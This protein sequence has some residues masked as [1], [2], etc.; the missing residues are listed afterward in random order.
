MYMLFIINTRFV[1]KIYAY[2]IAKLSNNLCIDIRYIV[3]FKSIKFLQKLTNWP[4]WSFG[5]I[6]HSIDHSRINNSSK[7]LW[8]IDDEL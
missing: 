7:Q 8:N 6:N 5:L 1:Y 3:Y 2:I 4:F